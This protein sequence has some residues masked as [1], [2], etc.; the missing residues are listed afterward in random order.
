MVAQWWALWTVR[1]WGRELRLVKLRMGADVEKMGE[2][3][4]SEKMRV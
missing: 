2:G 3:I 1:R 4:G